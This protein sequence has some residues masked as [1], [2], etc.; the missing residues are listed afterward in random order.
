MI[1]IPMAGLSSRFF[2]AGFSQPKY[3][4]MAHG[5]TLFDHSV[6]SFIRYFDNEHFV[7][8]IRDI[9]NT[10]SFV[11]ER[12]LALG[13]KSYE[14]IKLEGETRGQAETV[15]IALKNRHSKTPLT[16]FNIDTFRPNFTFPE[17]ESM[18]DGYLEV[19]EG[20]GEN[21]S[22]AKPLNDQD[23][24]V[25]ETAEK[26]AISNLCST[27]LYYFSRA[28]DFLDAFYRYVEKPKIEWAKGELY[29]APL[30]NLLIQK[31]LKIHFNLIKRDEVVF[32][33]IPSEYNDFISSEG[34]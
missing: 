15:A 33:G 19:F 20:Q 12:A 16:I 18:E 22:F 32:C 28:S 4:L 3:K 13:I 29:V 31:G 14:I 25:I 27:G 34:T 30:Y 8:I 5:I 26:S 11:C 2:D 7:F 10:H 17:I 6:M 9:Y 24:L 21:W 23:T 1:V